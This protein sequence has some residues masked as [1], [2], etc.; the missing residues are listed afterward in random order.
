[1]RV[2]AFHRN[3]QYSAVV[4][5]FKNENFKET[6]SFGFENTTAVYKHLA[7]YTRKETERFFGLKGKAFDKGI[8]QFKEMYKEYAAL[9]TNPNYQNII[10]S[11]R[12]GYELKPGG[13][14][15]SVLRSISNKLAENH[16]DFLALQS[17]AN[18]IND[19]INNLNNG[20]K[21]PQDFRKAILNAAKEKRGKSL[22]SEKQFNFQS[23]IL[24]YYFGKTAKMMGNT[25]E[26]LALNSVNQY[27]VDPLDQLGLKNAKLVGS[28]KQIVKKYEYVSKGDISFD[29]SIK[30]NSAKAVFG[31]IKFRKGKSKEFTA[32]KGTSLN[33]IPVNNKFKANFTN[34]FLSINKASD[35]QLKFLT[36]LI[37]DFALI[38]VFNRPIYFLTLTPNSATV[39][40]FYEMYEQYAIASS[41]GRPYIKQAAL[42]YSYTEGRSFYKQPGNNAKETGENFYKNVRYSTRLQ[43]FTQ[44]QGYMTTRYAMQKTDITNLVV[45]GK[46]IR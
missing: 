6:G 33:A 39:D 21:D 34:L 37:I 36:S 16:K 8:V 24:N 22:G 25:A 4:G 41:G 35:K 46:F 23:Y 15:R 5:N 26:I 7:E 2:G 27:I 29:L 32:V 14:P 3:K 10:K 19:N 31:S 38:G 18:T 1:L 30:G 9:S 17:K 44:N 12:F 45:M 28:K 13:S 20:A 11:I 43:A 40:F 42:K